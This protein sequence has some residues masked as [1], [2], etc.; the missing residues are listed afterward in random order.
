MLFSPLFVARDLSMDKKLG[1]YVRAC[2][3][4]IMT[5]YRD[6]V[7]AVSSHC[8][9]RMNSST[10]VRS[11]CIHTTIAKN[12][13]ILIVRKASVPC[14]L[15]VWSSAL[16]CH[17]SWMPLIVL[18]SQATE[19][20]WTN[21]DFLNPESVMVLPQLMIAK[22][23]EKSRLATISLLWVPQEFSTPSAGYRLL[24]AKTEMKYMYPFVGLCRDLHA[25]FVSP[26]HQ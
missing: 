15:K 22:P 3:F 1:S 17:A 12:P 6:L 21:L 16:F 13:S 25:D 23:T 10:S 11:V 18:L 7:R 14:E 20:H 4:V 8:N 2:F 24:R 9:L 26:L 19:C 5:L